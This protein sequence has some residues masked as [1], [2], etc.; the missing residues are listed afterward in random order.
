M[1][2]EGSHARPKPVVISHLEARPK[3]MDEP[4][5]QLTLEA[6]LDCVAMEA[7]ARRPPAERRWA[8]AGVPLATAVADIRERTPWE[9]FYLKLTTARASES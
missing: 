2:S 7:L 8:R 3:R 6:L 4:F 5:W 9:R 1:R